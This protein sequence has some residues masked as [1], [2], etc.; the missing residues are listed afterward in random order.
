MGRFLGTVYAV[1]TYVFFLAVFL[2]AIGFV[3]NLAVPKGIDSGEEGALGISLL[4][5]FGLLCL[6]ALQ[7]NIMARPSFKAAWTKII[8]E[9]VERSTFVLLTNVLLALMF[10]QWRPATGLIWSV[11]NETLALVLTAVSMVG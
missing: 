11:E 2:Y 5:N 10:W 1:V 6:F 7:H 3:G 8:P 9:Q 4:V